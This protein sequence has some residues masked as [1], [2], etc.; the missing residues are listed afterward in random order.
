MVGDDQ[1][2][3]IQVEIKTVFEKTEEIYGKFI[4]FGKSVG[5]NPVHRFGIWLGSQFDQFWWMNFG[6]GTKFSFSR[7]GPGFS[8]FLTKL[9]H[10]SGF[11]MGYDQVHSWISID[12]FGFE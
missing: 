4:Y 3:I 2:P 5:F 1:N 7:F 6:L 8:L 11:L 9:V 12:K 10:S